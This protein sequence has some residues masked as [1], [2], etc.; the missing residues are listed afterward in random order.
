MRKVI[1]TAIL[2]IV[3]A[4]TSVYSQT[5]AFGVHGAGPRVGATIDPDQIH[6]GG[7]L[8]LGDL[9]PRL[10]IFPEVE[11]GIGNDLTVIAPMFDI[12]YRFRD[13]WGSWNPYI[14]A[15]IGPVFVSADHGGSNSELG[16]SVQGG[17]QKR[18]LSQS[19][20]MFLE[21]KAGLMDYPDIK[22][23]LGWCFGS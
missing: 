21:F 15:G 19:G 8:D 20:F 7:H 14:G 12:A 6:F 11:V 5:R 1:L 18:L 4:T 22:F 3:L 17:I 13:N 2:A 9:A 16:M 10:M 23:T